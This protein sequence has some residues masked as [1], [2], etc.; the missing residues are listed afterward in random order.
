LKL[1]NNKKLEKGK[2]NKKQKN[3]IQSLIN[4]IVPI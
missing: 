2:D 3:W 4:I 1:K